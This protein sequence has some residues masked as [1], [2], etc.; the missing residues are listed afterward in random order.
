MVGIQRGLYEMTTAGR[1]SERK[2]REALESL[3]STGPVGPN[4]H[5]LNDTDQIHVVQFYNRQVCQ[6]FRNTLAEHGISSSIKSN[7]IKDSVYV[8][9]TAL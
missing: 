8:G 5:G 4:I 7:R 1:N 9:N 3:R 6:R 2:R